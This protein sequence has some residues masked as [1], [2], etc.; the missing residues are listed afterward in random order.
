MRR[1]MILLVLL[2]VIAFALRPED[3]SPTYEWVMDPGRGCRAFTGTHAIGGSVEFVEDPTGEG[4]GLVYKS[5]VPHSE[6]GFIEARPGCPL[7]GYGPPHYEKWPMLVYR[8]YGCVYEDDFYL[9]PCEFLMDVWVDEELLSTSLHTGGT[10]LLSVKDSGHPDWV[11]SA[12]IKLSD[13]SGRYGKAFLLLKWGDNGRDTA[14]ILPG[15]PAF[16]AEEWHTLRLVLRA[17]RTMRL[18][19]DGYLIA[20]H[21]LMPQYK[22]GII[23][24]HP[25]LYIHDYPWRGEYAVRGTLLI[26][27][28]E[29]RCYSTPACCP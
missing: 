12:Q 5:T 29:I 9:L 6:T 3:C 23:G 10:V 19:Q 17:D 16:T 11:T 24:G 20:E 25:G 14:R 15:S 18:Y 22:A 13:E 21:D 2:F 8:A 4:R 1:L 28:F 27:D 26:D 7:W